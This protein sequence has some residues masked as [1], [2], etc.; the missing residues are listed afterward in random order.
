[1]MPISLFT[2]EQVYGEVRKAIAE[3]LR[4]SEASIQ[5]DHSLIGDLGAESLDFI[6]MNYRLEQR[7]HLGMPRRYLVEHM[8]EFFGE[9]TAIDNEGRITE[10]AV[11]ILKARLG[12]VGQNLRAGMAV[13]EIPILV[14]PQTLV[15]IVREILASCPETCPSC[16]SE[17][18]TV[19][20]GAVITCGGCRKAAAL[21][22]GDDLVKKWLAE[23]K[24]K[25]LQTEGR[26][27]G[28]PRAGEAGGD[29]GAL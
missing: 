24:A 16:G 17:E 23:F 27:A 3:T 15:E 10:T 14:T 19:A 11:S 8:E 25:G 22:T 4:V 28:D 6:D 7:F 21:P 9:G 1:M 12:P 26:V 2:E 20:D 29:R 5:P 18:W 13:E